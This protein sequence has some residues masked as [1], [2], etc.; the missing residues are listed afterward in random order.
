MSHLIQPIGGGGIVDDLKNEASDPV[1][2]L[3]R[4][5]SAMM[6]GFSG[7]LAGMRANLLFSALMVLVTFLLLYWLYK[8]DGF[9]EH[10]NE[11]CVEGGTCEGMASA[12]KLYAE[13]S[14]NG[15]YNTP[16]VLAGNE[17]FL[18]SREAP[19]FSGV[20]NSTLRKEDDQQA[21]V[22]VLGKINQERLRRKTAR[23][24]D[25]APVQWEQHWDDWQKQNPR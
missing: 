10:A 13:S 15:L 2:S 19:F 22:R 4:G 14:D 1:G 17:T 8:V 3:K 20:S 6:G 5:F 9:S 7:L 24:A 11:Y 25:V 16:E 18:G 21:A 23:D 12:S